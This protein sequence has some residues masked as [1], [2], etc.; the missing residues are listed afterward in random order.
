MH[1][2][3]MKAF[4]EAGRPVGATPLGLPGHDVQFY[5]TDAHLT[6]VV[7]DFLAAGARVGQ[8]LIVIATEAHRQAFAYELRARRLDVEE[9]L[10]GREAVWLD[11]RETLAAFMEG[12]RPDRELFMATVGSVFERVLKRRYYLTVRAYGE[13]VDLLWKDGNTEGALQLE[14]LWNE[15]AGKYSHSLLCGYSMDNFLHAAGADEL[16]RVCEHHTYALPLEAPLDA[17]A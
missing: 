3:L 16:R 1:L 10:S 8:P 2:H 4:E 9:V 7:A 6:R 15:I 5:Q 12:G 14:A 11:A 17:S 13:M